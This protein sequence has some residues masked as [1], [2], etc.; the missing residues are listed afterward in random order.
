MW[1]ATRLYNG[2]VTIFLYVNDIANVSTLL[3]PILFADDTNVFL[4]GNN[5]DQMIE[6]MNGELNNVFL[7]LNSNK[8]SLNVK[9]PQFMV[10]SLR[11]HIITNTDMC[12]NNQIIDRVEHTM[13]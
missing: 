12:I 13:F 9:N 2:P 8:L 5:I 6:I 11:K 1:S 10:F 7:W 4:T 3:L